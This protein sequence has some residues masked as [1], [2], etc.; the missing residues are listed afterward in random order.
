MSLSR[1]PWPG[2]SSSPN[3][4]SN[5][6]IQRPTNG[7]RDNAAQANFYASLR[8]KSL[9][10]T[11]LFHVRILPPQV[12]L[13]SYNNDY[14]NA[15]RSIEMYAESVNLPGVNFTT[16]QNRRQGIGYQQKYVSDV[17]FN[18]LTVSFINN[19]DM[20]MSILFSDWMNSIVR[21]NEYVEVPTPDVTQKLPY[22]FEYKSQYIAGDFYIAVFDERRDWVSEYRILE[23]FP[24]SMSDISM[25]WNST[26]EFARFTVN[27][28][29]SFWNVSF[30]ADRPVP[31]SQRIEEE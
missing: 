26:D 4:P 24:I 13:D 2:Q 3:S 1:P 15:Y 18:D 29:Y 16:T 5:E 20:D 31:S 22:E 21:F 11:N 25:N 6:N 10:R 14:T 8:T 28:A 30:N 9:Q 12:I 7:N 17:T 27:F 23:A 19:G